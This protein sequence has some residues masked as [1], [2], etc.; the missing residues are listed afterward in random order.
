MSATTTSVLMAL[1]AIPL[2]FVGLAIIFIGDNNRNAAQ[3]ILGALVTLCGIFL[4]AISVMQ[5][6]GIVL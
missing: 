6:E 3:A 2:L 4:I 1:V 5:L